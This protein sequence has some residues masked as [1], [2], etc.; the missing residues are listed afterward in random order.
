M[1]NPCK[2]TVINLT[3]R[4]LEKMKDDSTQYIK[5]SIDGVTW[6]TSLTYR[7]LHLTASGSICGRKQGSV[8]RKQFLQGLADSLKS[9]MFTTVASDRPTQSN[10]Q[11][12][13]FSEFTSLMSQVYRTQYCLIIRYF[14]Y[15]KQQS[16]DSLKLCLVLI[17]SCT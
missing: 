10:C 4:A 1:L 6:V 17:D 11:C 9:R 7:T 3:I 2:T 15:H 13:K 5:E 16:T 14:Y 12:E 8:D